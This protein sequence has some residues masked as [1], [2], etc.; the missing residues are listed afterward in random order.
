MCEEM[1][2]QRDESVNGL[3]RNKV[4]VIQSVRGYRVSEDALIL[5]WFVR[6]RAGE[7]ILDAGTGCGVI[8]FGLA[9]RQPSVFVL[10]LEIQQAVADRA[11]RGVVLNNLQSCVT[12]V[13]GDVR[14]ADVFLRPGQFDAVV[15]NPPYHEPGR[16]RISLHEEKA[17]SRHQLMM[18]LGDLFRVSRSLLKPTGRLCLI[19]P[20]AA[21]GRIRE[22]MKEAG[23]KPACMLWI[24][25]YE[26]ADPCLLC[27]EARLEPWVHQ[28]K[29]H[30]LVLY[31]RPGRRTMD[32]ET[33]LA[34]EEVT[35][36]E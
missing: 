8:A 1:C 11:R 25:P 5:T 20:A 28:T 22:G 17:V 29:S 6:P 12:I 34:G 24:H 23:F 26:S 19:Y 21:A 16:G 14:H 3:F 31:D 2:K 32:A 27:V 35:L 4:R 13:Q 15:S 33:I 18:P 30:T 9:A 36:P 7:F 10:G